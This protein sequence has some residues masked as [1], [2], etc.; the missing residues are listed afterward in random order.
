MDVILLDLFEMPIL[1]GT[2]EIEMLNISIT[3]SRVIE[4]L[5]LIWNDQ[6]SDY[7]PIEQK[8]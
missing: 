4:E 2:Y 7:I 6:V 8:Y 5:G 3:E 1:F